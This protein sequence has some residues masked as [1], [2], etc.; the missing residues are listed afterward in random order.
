MAGD[1]VAIKA[2]PESC[3]GETSAASEFGGV[4]TGPRDRAALCV[5]VEAL[6]A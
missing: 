4:P 2:P 6:Q 3:Y 1:E 5:L